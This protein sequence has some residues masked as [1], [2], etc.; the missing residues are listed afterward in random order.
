M[1]HKLVEV[2]A[3]IGLELGQNA[4]EHVTVFVEHTD[5]LLEDVKMEGGRD[6]LAAL[7]PLLSGARQQAGTQPVLQVLI[8]V[9]LVEEL[10]VV[11]HCLRFD[12][13]ADDKVKAVAEPHTQQI[14][15]LGQ[16]FEA[17]LRH[18]CGDQDVCFVHV[19]IRIS[20]RNDAKNEYLPA[21]G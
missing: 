6:E 11:E 20:M 16:P 21:V 1:A 8:K 9:G 15:I 7:V 12:R 10:R 18:L 3:I 2:Y 14:A 13:M 4:D 5:V 19:I 17:R